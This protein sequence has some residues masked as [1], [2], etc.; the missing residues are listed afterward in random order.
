MSRHPRTREPAA[1]VHRRLSQIRAF[2]EQK[3]QCADND[4]FRCTSF[5]RDGDKPR[6]HLPLELFHKCKIFY[7]E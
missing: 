1:S 3:L 4:R 6:S 2:A 7:S 5:S